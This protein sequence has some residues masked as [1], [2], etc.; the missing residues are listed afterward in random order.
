[1][2]ILA[3]EF[4][5]DR[6]TVAVLAGDGLVCQAGEDRGRSTPAFAMIER[7]LGEAGVRREEIDVIA[8]GL[9]P[10]SYTGIRAAI[11]ITQGW[12][13]ARGVRLAGLSSVVGL[14]AQLHAAGE[15]GRRWLAM[16]A[17]RREFYL[18]GYDL[19]EDGAR[20][21]EPLRIV[22]AGEIESRIRTGESVV[23][24]DLPR[25]FAGARNACPEAAT[26][27]RLALKAT[28]FVPGE[29]LEP[30]YLREVSFVKAPPARQ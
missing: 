20:E 6:R 1:M 18:A 16:D 29:K 12:Q 28:E 13:L 2:R 30:I 22:P 19:V 17:Q 10:G 15:R 27:A 3:L 4:S 26:L 11:A 5:S 21:I 24:P 9:G 25:A 7:V 23:G 8:V 14:A